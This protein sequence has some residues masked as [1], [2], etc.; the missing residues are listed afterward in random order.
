LGAGAREAR[1]GEGVCGFLLFF[2][3]SVRVESVVAGVKSSMTESGEEPSSSCCGSVCC[4]A[5]VVF[6]L[7]VPS[8]MLVGCDD[9][10]GEYYGVVQRLDPKTEHIGV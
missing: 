8:R 5:G 1:V 10:L 9:K 6:R 4:V 2:F 3:F 7:E